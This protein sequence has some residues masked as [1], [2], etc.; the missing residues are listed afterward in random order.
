MI[1]LAQEAAMAVPVSWVLASGAALAGSITALAG[2][3]YKS[4]N[5]RITDLQAA[6][7]RRGD[8]SRNQEEMIRKLQTDVQDL[9]RG[10]GHEGC[11][12]RRK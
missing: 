7:D 8:I 1:T 9:K 4:Q 12:W 6:L 5:A 10:C 3:I 2:I 11:L